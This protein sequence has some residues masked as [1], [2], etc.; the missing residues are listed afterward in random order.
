MKIHAEVVQISSRDG[1]C[2][3][4]WDA[5]KFRFSNA[6]QRCVFLK[7]V[8]LQ[9]KSAFGRS[10]LKSELNLSLIRGLEVNCPIGVAIAA[11]SRLGSVNY[12]ITV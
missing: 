7:P 11:L 10:R 8:A 12:T 2:E 1:P 4:H 6:F 9:I 5:A 3:V